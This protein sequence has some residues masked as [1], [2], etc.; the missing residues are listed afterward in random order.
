VLAYKQHHYD[1]AGSHRCADD[2]PQT[3]YKHFEGLLTHDTAVLAETG[4]SWFNCQKLRLPNGCRCRPSFGL[5]MRRQPWCNARPH[6][7]F[8][9]DAPH[10]SLRSLSSCVAITATLP[11]SCRRLVVM[12]RHCHTVR[13]PACRAAAAASCFPL[14]CSSWRVI[15]GTLAASPDSRPQT[16]RHLKHAANAKLA[17]TLS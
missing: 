5:C 8:R 3:L 16:G 6:P 11:R 14:R 9:P 4:D 13:L 10:A 1:A 2:C 7:A 15:S 12:L 17:F